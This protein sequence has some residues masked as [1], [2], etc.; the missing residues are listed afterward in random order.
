MLPSKV[1]TSTLLLAA[2]FSAT[3]AS[4]QVNVTAIFGAGNPNTGW[5]DDVSA[6]GSLQLALRGKHRDNGATPW[7]AGNVYTFAG[8]PA[9]NP[10]RSSVQWEFSINTDFTNTGTMFLS[11]YIYRVSLDV[12]PSYGVS[13]VSFSPFLAYSDNSLGTNATANGAGAE[14]GSFALQAAALGSYS[15]AQNSQNMAFPPY[16]LGP[17]IMGAFN[18]RLEAA[19]LTDTAFDD[20]L[21]SVSIQL[22]IGMVP[23][24]TV[25]EPSTYGLIG[26]LSL[27]AVVAWRR[28]RRA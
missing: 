16:A 19:A 20:P 23:P 5:S 27:A 10:A 24:S 28:R 14:F 2:L 13:W 6:D 22:I 26:V 21:A 25:P 18:V 9:A 3:V 1:T 17:N 12:D 15:M 11:D 8:G 7:G 4:A